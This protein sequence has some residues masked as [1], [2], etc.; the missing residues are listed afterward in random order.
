MYLQGCWQKSGLENF[1]AS[2]MSST[3]RSSSGYNSRISCLCGS[4]R[5]WAPLWSLHP[6]QAYTHPVGEAVV[7]VGGTDAV[8]LWLPMGRGGM[9]LIGTDLAGDLVRFRQGDPRQAD[10]RPTEALWGIAGERPVY[11]YEAQLR[12]HPAHARPADAWCKALASLVSDKTGISPQPLLPGGAPG[13]IVITGDDDQAFLEKYQEQLDLL[14]D[15]PIT[16]FLHP[17]T[18]HTPQTLRTML[19]RPGIEVELHPDALD[20]PEAYG[21]TL[22]E[23]S[24]WF[25]RLTGRGPRLARNHGF[26][27]DGYWGHLPHWL[28]N[29]IIGSSNLP[30]FD[31]RVL[32]GSLLPARMVYEG[33]M[34]A[35]WS[36]LTAVGDG[37]RFAAGYSDEQAGQKVLDVASEIKA[38]GI[39]G[40]MAL[41]LHPQN[42]GETRGMHLAVKQLVAEGF[43]AWNL[44]QCLDWFARRDGLPLG[45]EEPGS[46]AAGRRGAAPAGWVAAIG[47]KL[48]GRGRA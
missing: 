37:V 34:T 13:A 45:Q 40:V 30:G 36:L 17:L 28:R 21:A 16:Y 3:Q 9:L 4:G 33:R 42:I 32:N 14:E 39:P 24:A 41:N 7:T 5:A 47:R 1:W 46:E 48:A 8:W 20:A 44:G 35:H 26:L 27:N 19:G 12:D 22:D 38:S 31:G 2:Q 10:E 11:L 15:L 29:G 43:Q 23:Q 25:R 18:R 6:A